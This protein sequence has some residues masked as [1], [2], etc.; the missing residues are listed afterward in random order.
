LRDWKKRESHSLS[1]FI[2]FK[3]EQN[4]I[5]QNAFLPSGQSIPLT[6]REKEMKEK[7]KFISSPLICRMNKKIRIPF[8]VGTFE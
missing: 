5:Q 6:S 3:A 4:N 7:Q 8:P 2:F 1:L